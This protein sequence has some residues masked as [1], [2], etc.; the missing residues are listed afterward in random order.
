MASI[1]IE[2][3]FFIAL[4]LG[5]IG[6]FIKHISQG[7]KV[8]LD[9]HK[10][11]QNQFTDLQKRAVLLSLVLI[12]KA[13]GRFTPDEA[14]YLHNVSHVISYDL[15]N[16][17]QILNTQISRE[18]MHRQLDTLNDNQKNWY[19]VAAKGMAH[20]N[21][22]NILEKDTTFDQLMSS[23]HIDEGRIDRVLSMSMNMMHAFN[24]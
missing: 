14:E 12:A 3:I 13:D 2:I 20:M 19:V 17:Y 8:K 21:T 22:T 16:N 23:M 10:Q 18:V 4:G 1:L 6:T 15:L 24:G 7:V 11:S 9:E 5:A